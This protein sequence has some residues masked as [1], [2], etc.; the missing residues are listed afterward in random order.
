MNNHAN[1]DSAIEKFVDV[2]RR[3]CTWSESAPGSPHQDMIL[4]RQLLSE[5]HLAAINLP[6]VD[7]DGDHESEAILHE[8]WKEI[9]ERFSGLPLSG[10]WDV[11]DPLKEE[12]KEAVFNT[13]ADDLADI[14][15]DV[16]ENF[17]L[18]EAG[19]IYEAVWQWRFNFLIHWG[20]HLTGAQRALH[21]YFV[22]KEESNW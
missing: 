1:I 13:L 10:Y 11:F 12:E 5:L 14:Y 6:L 8:R 18:Y 17:S 7:F 4:A 16:K 21:S 15:R 2:A 22:N 20:R 9:F 19:Y 3:Y